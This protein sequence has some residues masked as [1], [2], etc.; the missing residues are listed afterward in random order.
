MMGQVGCGRQ[1]Y[2][3]QWAVDFGA[4]SGNT[5]RLFFAAGGGSA[6]GVDASLET[7]YER[8]WCYRCGLSFSVPF[9]VAPPG[10]VIFHLRLEPG[11]FTFNDF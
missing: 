6:K 5:A 7:T 1:G 11:H 10:L 9:S 4:E 3:S 8:T 2:R